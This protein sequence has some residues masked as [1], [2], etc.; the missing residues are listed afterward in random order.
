MGTTRV[1]PVRGSI[2]WQ[3]VFLALMATTTALP[4]NF[5][6]FGNRHH[7]GGHRL[8]GGYSVSHTVHTHRVPHCI[9][10]FEEVEKEVCRFELEKKCE[11]KTQEYEVITGYEKGECKEIEVCK[12]NFYHKREARG[13]GRIQCKKEKKEVCKRTYCGEEVKR[14]RSLSD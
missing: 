7:H 6:Y 10:E 4:S 2:M 13:Y 3:T 9:Q 12:R 11:T 5:V 14:L 8:G 1:Q